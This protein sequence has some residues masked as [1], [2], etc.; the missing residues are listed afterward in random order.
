[1]V[2]EWRD[3]TLTLPGGAAD[4]ARNAQSG[5]AQR[6]VTA[7]LAEVRDDVAAEAHALGDKAGEKVVAEADAVKDEAVRALDAFSGSLRSA[8][9][10]FEGQR[11]GFVGDMLGM[12]A[13]RL[14]D[15]ARSMDDVTSSEMI[16][17][18]RRYA[19]RNPTAFLAVTAIAGFALGRV[20]T[21]TGGRT[22]GSSSGALRRS[23][24]PAATRRAPA[25]PG[26]GY[27][28]DTVPGRT[29]P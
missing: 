16:D 22:Q 5:T 1:M 6:P 8:Q 15:A 19:R 14:S 10:Q 24:W 25:T 9:D 4:K 28:P 27:S 12:A 29:L 21:A 11:L 13:G 17:S 23:D 3:D 18:V 2:D 26:T 20:A 7:A